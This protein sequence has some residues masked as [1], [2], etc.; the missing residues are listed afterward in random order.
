MPVDFKALQQKLVDYK[1]YDAWQYV[2]GLL[3]S[4]R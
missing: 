2:Q 3:E 4:M 1:V